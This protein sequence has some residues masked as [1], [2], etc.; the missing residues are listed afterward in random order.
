[1]EEGVLDFEQHLKIIENF[2]SPGGPKAIV[3]N[4][5]DRPIPPQGKSNKF[6]ECYSVATLLYTLR[7]LSL[8]SNVHISCEVGNIF[9]DLSLVCVEN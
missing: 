6:L 2:F 3:F 7:P 4:C 9:E 8:Y 5:T 1:M